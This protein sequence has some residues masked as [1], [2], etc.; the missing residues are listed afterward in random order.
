MSENVH[1]GHRSRMRRKFRD[2][3]DR[4]FDDYELLEMFLYFV[5]PVRD[6]NP[7]AKALL[8]RFG[9]IGGVL[10]AS[11]EELLE[12]SGVGERVA[13]LIISAARLRAI[14]LQYPRARGYAS[15][16]II[17]RDSILQAALK[18]RRIARCIWHPSITE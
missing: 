11:R 6:T 5:V 7:L 4:F 16:T 10:R 13:E 1:I 2:Y 3:G 17:L 14:I 9:G 15:R 18:A 12:V 8:A